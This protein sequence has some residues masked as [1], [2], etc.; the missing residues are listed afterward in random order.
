MEDSYLKAK[1]LLKKYNQEHLLLNY[2]KLNKSNQKKL[3]NQIF[4]KNLFFFFII[5]LLKSKNLSLR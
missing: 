3:L 4:S 2:E 1:D 5:F